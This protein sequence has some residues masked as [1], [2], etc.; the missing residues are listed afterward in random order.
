MRS[1]TPYAAR[2]SGMT[3][4]RALLGFIIGRFGKRICVV[5]YL[6]L[7]RGFDSILLA[8]SVFRRLWYFT[9]AA[10]LGP[11]FGPLFPGSCA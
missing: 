5:L 3:A 6:G 10:F 11:V 8:G 9:G 1:A 4:G 7:A 2:I